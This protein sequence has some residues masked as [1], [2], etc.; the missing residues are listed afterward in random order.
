MYLRYSILLF[1][2]VVMGL[3]S[4]KNDDNVFAPVN[5]SYINFVNAS[6]D[7]LNFFL[8][9]T[10]QNNLS[11]INPTSQTFYIKVP[12]GQQNL[13]FKKTGSP[14]VL[15]NVPLKLAENF[16]YSIYVADEASTGVF[17]SQDI[18][19]TSGISKGNFFKLRF[20]NAS[21]DAGNLSVSIG[22]TASF[23][24][25]AYA[26]TSAL[27]VVGS[28]KK[29]I[30]VYQAGATL[31]LIDTIIA[32][33]PQFIYTLFSKGLI[34]GKGTSKIGVGLARNY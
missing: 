29:T 18:L 22:D 28:G 32:M 24:A 20:V 31:P 15:F 4:C 5:Y 34:N 14:V 2:I 10:R 21:P 30:K 8:N 16:N 7:T 25:L 13:Q 6:G 9:G 27:R 12:D 19:D 33:Q 26:Q 17:Y 3:L 11:G 1:I 23:S